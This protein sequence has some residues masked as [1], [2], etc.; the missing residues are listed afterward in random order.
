MIRIMSSVKILKHN[1]IY[2]RCLV[3]FNKLRLKRLKLSTQFYKEFSV[4]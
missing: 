2:K 3:I 4:A 1:I